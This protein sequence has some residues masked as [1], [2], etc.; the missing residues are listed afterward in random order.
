MTKTRPVPVYWDSCVFIDCIQKF[1]PHF[2]DIEPILENAIN[3]TIVI[4]ASAISLAEVVKLNQ[5]TD[6]EEKQAQTIQDFF[7]NDYI[8]LRALDRMTASL[9][10][11]FV[12]KHNLKPAD[13]VH[14]ATA[15]HAGCHALLTYDGEQRGN[16]PKRNKTFLL[17]MDRKIDP[18][19]QI[20]MPGD[21]LRKHGSL[22]LFR[23]TAQP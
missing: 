10:G 21:Y 23:N 22:P 15:I 13:A 8:A 7:E 9:A 20:E 12:R 14:V 4:V 11:S 19:L 2:A 6:P 18:S 3:G 1:Q 17:D 5:S 16:K